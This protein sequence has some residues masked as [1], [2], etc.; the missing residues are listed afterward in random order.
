MYGR[1]PLISPSPVAVFLPPSWM[2]SGQAEASQEIRSLSSHHLSP[3][4]HTCEPLK[5]HKKKYV[6][7]NRQ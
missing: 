2:M 3:K 1:T 4:Y 7:P 6:V 5:A